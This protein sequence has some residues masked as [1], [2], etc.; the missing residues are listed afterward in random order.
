MVRK[1]V[2]HRYLFWYIYETK[3]KKIASNNKCLVQMYQY[4]PSKPLHAITYET[5]CGNAIRQGNF[6]ISAKHF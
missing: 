5:Y 4:K 2:L 6:A 3:L 1:K